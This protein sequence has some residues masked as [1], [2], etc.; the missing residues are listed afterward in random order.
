[1][2]LDPQII[3]P[4]CGAAVA[5]SGA[6]IA[7]NGTLRMWIRDRA[8]AR[9]ILATPEQREQLGPIPPPYPPTGTSPAIALIIGAGLAIGIPFASGNAHPVETLQRLGFISADDTR[10]AQDFTPD[11]RTA[12]LFGPQ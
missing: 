11:T 4:I 2:T 7:S 3:G 5:L 1:M 12:G 8:R 9:W 10:R 6:I